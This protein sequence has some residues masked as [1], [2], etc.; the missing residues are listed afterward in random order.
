MN[1]EN[2][3]Q[4][5]IRHEDPKNPLTDQE[6]SGKSGV[7][8][9]IVTKF[10][11]TNGIPDS[12]ERRKGLLLQEMIKYLSK[13]VEISERGLT[14]LLQDNGFR[15]ARYAVK[16]L[17]EEAELMLGVQKAEI[18]AKDERDSGNDANPNAFDKMIGY[19]GS[20]KEQVG[21]AK[22]AVIYPPH[23]LNTLILGPSGA[24]KSFLAE[25]MHHFAVET[26]SFSEDA[27]FMTFNC[28][29]YANNPQLLLAQ[30]FG[31]KK[32]A[33][34]GANED[35][36]GIVE[37]CNHGILFLDEIHRLPAEGQEILFYLLDK[38]KYRR[39][40]ESTLTR[41]ATIMLIGATT[42][43]PK[44]SLLLTFRRRI[45]MIIELPKFTDRPKSERFALIK[46]F[47]I[48]ESKRL[49]KKLVVKSEVL[50]SFLTYSCMGNIG[51][52]LSDIKVSCARAFL[53]STISQEN[54]ILVNFQHLPDYVRDEILSNYKDA[55]QEISQYIYDDLI[56]SGQSSLYDED[57]QTILQNN[58]YQFIDDIYSEMKQEGYDN[59][60]INSVIGSMIEK[61][62]ERVAMEARSHELNLD[63]VA[64]IIGKDIYNLARH[65]YELAKEHLTYLQD[66]IIAPL[67]IH[68]SSTY[69]RT[70]HHQEIR[71]PNLDHV[72]KKYR[73]EYQI[74]LKLV[75]KINQE[76]HVHLSEDE[77]SFI[78]MYL[79]NFQADH[80]DQ[81][82]HVGVIVLS[83]GHVACGMADV[84][85]RLLGVEHAVGLEMDLSDSPNLMLEK[86]IQTVRKVNQGKGCLL[87]A[88]MG[89]LVIFGDIIHER[90][91]IPV[92]VIG[93]VDTL[94]VIE[95]VRRALLPED[96]LDQ[97]ADELD[98][99]NY[100]YNLGDRAE[101]TQGKV[102]VTLCITGQGAAQKIKDY[103]YD[104]LGTEMKN[105][106]VIPIGYTNSKDIHTTITQVVRNRKIVA[107]VGT[108]DPEYGNVPFI[109]AEELVSGSALIHLRN[110]MNNKI[111]EETPKRLSD[112]ISQDLI[113]FESGYKDDMIDKM[114]Q[115]LIKGHKVDDNYLLSVYKREAQGNTYLDVGVAIPHGEGRFVTKPAIAVT[116]LTEPIIWDGEHTVDFVFLLALDIKS[117]GY[118]E[119]LYRLISDQEV[120]QK[121]RSAKNSE[122]FY[123]VMINYTK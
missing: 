46:M 73:R 81:E 47:F 70:L 5:V 41:T 75:S 33:F 111:E 78:A 48:A 26:N 2:L 71:N 31:Y 77:A 54:R 10:R 36:K 67:S 22:A 43:D 68:L 123:W 72:K 106:E 108:I 51:Q 20:L 121:L 23:G 109:T 6:I 100:Y 25:L 61:K 104:S 117:K 59:Q 45:P 24:G 44:K 64:N 103:L 21:Q 115:N 56:L 28:A 83:H 69:G 98:N 80:R 62:L 49:G 122:E 107:I 110:L 14:E 30:L 38:G 84:A 120:L 16:G 96:S 9:E 55:D 92:R 52:L 63:T 89:S 53:Q 94:M 17:K 86:T 42:E 82:S 90:I 1:T 99:K 39:M 97:I 12:R 105:I 35:K 87:L 3:I 102:I 60:K 8:R 34:T 101:N 112:V 119:Q 11:K 66:K 85:N 79:K 57:H 50:R 74:A 7:L 15:I 32:G 37:L 29:D 95:C 91:G 116:K 114:C 4:S 40:G 18:Q 13:D 118:F 27:P 76:L 88:D 113:F 58:I 93:R 65:C 19:D